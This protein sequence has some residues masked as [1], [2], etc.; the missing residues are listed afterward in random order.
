MSDRISFFDARAKYSPRVPA[1]LLDASHLRLESIRKT[2]LEWNI[3]Q[4][5]S[6]TIDAQQE[7]YTFEKHSSPEEA[8]RPLN[9][10]VV[11][12]GGQ[13][14]GGHAVISGLVDALYEYHPKSQCIG[15]LNGPQG[16]LHNQ[17]LILTRQNSLAVRHTGG[18]DLLGSGRDK[19]EG[20]Q[21]LSCVLQVTK[22]HSLDGL[23]IIGGDDSNT[24]ALCMSM[25][26]AQHNSPCSIVGVPKTI[27]GDL[28]A[29][30]LSLTFG[31]DTATKTY[32][33]IIGNLAKDTLSAKK[34]Y[35]FIRLMGRH[36]SH[37]TLEC[38]MS[39]YPN[40]ALISEEVQHRKMTLREV[41]LDICSL[42]EERLEA[43]KSYGVVLIPEGLI[44]HFSDVSRLIAELN[45]VLSVHKPLHQDLLSIA[46]VEERYARVLQEISSDA[47]QCLMHFP[48]SLGLQLVLDRDP[49][50]NVNVSKIETEKVLG[51][52]V[53][54]E[55][56]KRTKEDKKKRPFS[57]QTF[58]CGYEG[59]AQYPTNFDIDYG[60]SLGR[61]AAC[62]VSFRRNGY[63]VTIDGLEKEFSFWKPCCVPLA[64]MATIEMR[65]G[66]SKPVIKKFL[67]DLEGAPFQE[68][69]RMR[70]QWRMHDSYLQPGPIQYW[71]HSACEKPFVLMS[72]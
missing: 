50:G 63:L 20:E 15:F 2:T 61:A 59:R 64:S 53:E 13:A 18:F 72:Q 22:E 24:N 16:V 66:Y 69:C 14:P 42:I 3:A 51:F 32:S 1:M 17:F 33:E 36:A 52:L 44:E 58:F 25:Y 55:L 9:V 5:F 4:L 28:R 40:L 27:D 31:F 6:E 68:F 23:V 34:Q 54:H 57:F 12:S 62:A 46:D 48:R 70:P 41:V 56:L 43:G 39:T 60:V 67:V 71:Y 10:G 29:P 38:A 65:H 35:F 7:V 47:Q 37:I 8:P 19:I 21:A 26:F 45:S 30:E 11:F 49:H